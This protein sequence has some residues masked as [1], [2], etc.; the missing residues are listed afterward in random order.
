MESKLDKFKEDVNSMN[1]V[2]T[3]SF[4]LN[5]DSIEPDK[6]THPSDEYEEES[7][8]LPYTGKMS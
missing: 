7:F 2:I 1:T 5:P 3:E 4:E 6:L 8:Y